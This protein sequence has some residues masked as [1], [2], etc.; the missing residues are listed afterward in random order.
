MDCSYHVLS[1][2]LDEVFA[3]AVVE[4]RNGLGTIFVFAGGNDYTYGVD[5]NF[6]GLVNSRYTVSVGAT[7]KNGHRKCSHYSLT[8]A[9]ILFAF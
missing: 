5:V 8:R 2:V 9:F 1:P 7:G 3:K 4:G 6:D